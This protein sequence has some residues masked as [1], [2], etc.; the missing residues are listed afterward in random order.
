EI[1]A[2]DEVT[3]QEPLCILA[4][5]AGNDMNSPFLSTITQYLEYKRI[6]TLRFNFP[7]KTAGK[8]APDS[9]PVLEETW[10]RVIDWTGK[11]IEH[12]GLFIGGKSMGGRIAS[13][14]AA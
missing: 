7:Y 9:S 8:K 5:G 11:N 14:V 13:M 10:K 1:L 6:N 2:P 12:N 3:P 4:H